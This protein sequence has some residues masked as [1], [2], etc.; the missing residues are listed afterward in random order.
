MI[1]LCRQQM[2]L[3][4]LS[5]KCFVVA[6]YNLPLPI[7]PSFNSNLWGSAW[8]KLSKHDLTCQVS[9]NVHFHWFDTLLCLLT[10]SFVQICLAHACTDHTHKPT[11]HKVHTHTLLSHT[12]THTPQST[13][14]AQILSVQWSMHQSLKVILQCLWLYRGVEG[15]DWAFARPGAYLLLCDSSVAGR[16]L[17][18]LGVKK[19]EGPLTDYRREQQELAF[20][21]EHHEQTSFKF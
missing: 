12:H 9:A 19:V 4:T 8:S 20:T 11:W 13:H 5:L 16:N 6:N 10:R 17:C 15:V 7:S 1:H 21:F 3:P 18:F 14:R 2:N